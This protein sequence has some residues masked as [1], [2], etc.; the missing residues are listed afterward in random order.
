MKKSLLIVLAI[1]C[2]SFVKAQKETH[3]LIQTNMGDIT[4]KLFDDTPKHRDNFIKLVKEAKYDGSIFH[5]VI[6][7][8]MIQGGGGPDGSKDLGELVPPEFSQK[9]IH[10]A[11]KLCAARMGDQVNPGRMSS[12]SQFYI[13]H[14]RK[15][16][17]N[18]I[19]SLGARTGFAYTDEQIKEYE[20]KGGAPHLDGQYTVFGEVVSGMDVVDKI[21]RTPVK[22]ERPAEDITMK[23]KIVKK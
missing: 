23:M 21:A 13:V 8:F 1:F 18:D 16:A 11:G 14:G 4:V 5:R 20:V 6:K 10:T 3:V 2:F 7:D 17:A 15:F 22:G 12:G 9:H 19:K